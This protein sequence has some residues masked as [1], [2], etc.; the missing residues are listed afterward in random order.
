MFACVAMPGDAVSVEQGG[1]RA[2]AGHCGC[3]VDIFHVSF[4]CGQQLRTHN[5]ENDL[6]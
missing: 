3:D 2:D 6:G 4:L 5:Q 1:K